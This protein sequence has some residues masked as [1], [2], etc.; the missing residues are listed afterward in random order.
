MLEVYSV[1]MLYLLTIVQL[2]YVA[3]SIEFVLANHLSDS[4][5]LPSLEPWITTS[6]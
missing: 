4:K 5:N 6:A 1:I 3:C 2:I